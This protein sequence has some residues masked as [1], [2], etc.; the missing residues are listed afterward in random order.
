MFIQEPG[1]STALIVQQFRH[2]HPGPHE[3]EHST[4]WKRQA[5]S[6]QDRLAW[7]RGLERFLP[8]ARELNEK[9]A[10]LHLLALAAV[11]DVPLGTG[12][13]SKFQA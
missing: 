9:A 3:D 6:Q 4:R 1:A 12:S 8:L 11:L 13:F 2:Q 10:N 7:L 5:L